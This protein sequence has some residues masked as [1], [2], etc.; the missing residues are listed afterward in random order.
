MA[1][2][3]PPVPGRAAAFTLAAVRRAM[4]RDEDAVVVS[5][6]TSAAHL[7]APLTGFDAALSLRRL[8][9]STR[10]DAL[11][12]CVE[13]G[14]PLTSGAGALRTRLE[15]GLLLAAMRGFSQVTLLAGAEPG[16]ISVELRALGGAAGE[17]VVGSPGERDLVTGILGARGPRITVEKIANRGGGELIDGDVT[18]FGPPEAEAQDV[19]RRTAARAERAAYHAEHAAA[20]AA[21]LLLG[22]N[23][24]KLG[25]PL[26]R[27]VE[28]VRARVIRRAGRS[29]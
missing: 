14:T 17:I 9:R 16:A 7:H 20:R 29:R 4:E 23:A 19:A 26:R 13:P 8:R 3:Y 18:V 1:G 6:R 27:F 10:S 21:H 24:H 25:G 22:D 15:S 2:S 12:M 11:V 28:P 5:P